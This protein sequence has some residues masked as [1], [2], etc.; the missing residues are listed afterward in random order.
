MVV[1]DNRKSYRPGLATL[2]QFGKGGHSCIY[3]IKSSLQ[4]LCAPW[5]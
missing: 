2:S 3:T 1:Y 5:P 4:F